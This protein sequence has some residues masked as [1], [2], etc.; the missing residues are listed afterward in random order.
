MIP[1]ESLFLEEISG[2]AI[3]KII[4][5]GQKTLMMLKLKFVRNKATLDIT[6]NMRETLIFDGKTT[7]GILDLRS[8]GYYKIKQGVLQQNLNKYYHF[9]EANRMCEAFNKMVETVR[10]E[11]KDGKKEKYPWVDDTDERK[12]MTDKEILD[13]YIDLK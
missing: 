6:N 1:I 10:Q 12:Y 8:L 13:K 3:V 2:M 11:E 5:Q 4:D 9:E 7:I